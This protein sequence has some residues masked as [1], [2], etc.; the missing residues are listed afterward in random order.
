MSYYI[1]GP[2]Y[3]FTPDIYRPLTMNYTVQITALETS[4][5]AHSP[6]QLYCN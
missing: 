2:N 5:F 6:I 3:S 4:V 1:T